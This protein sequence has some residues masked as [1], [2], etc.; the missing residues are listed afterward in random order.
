M[1][2][3]PRARQQERVLELAFFGVTVVG[4]L[5]VADLHARAAGDAPAAV[6]IEAIERAGGKVAIECAAERIIKQ[7]HARVDV[8]LL[9]RAAKVFAEKHGVV[10]RKF[11][12]ENGVAVIRVAE[13]ARELELLRNLP[14]V[15]VG[16]G[17]LVAAV[18]RAEEVIPN[19]FDGIQSETVGVGAINLP[20]RRAGRDSPA[21]TRYR[22]S[23]WRREWQASARCSCQSQRRC[24]RVCSSS[25]RGCSDGG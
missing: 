6:R 8:G 15:A 20:T 1:T 9:W 7:A 16:G 13:A 19:V 10:A 14:Q 24:H 3:R 21:R 18:L 11:R 12:V 4:A 5:R 17:I 22:N 25:T 23:G 2:G